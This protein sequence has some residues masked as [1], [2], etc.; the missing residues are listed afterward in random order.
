MLEPAPEETWL[1]LER[2]LPEKWWERKLD[3]P[4]RYLATNLP[5]HGFLEGSSSKV[6]PD[7]VL[8]CLQAWLLKRGETKVFYFLTESC[9]GDQINSWVNIDQL[10]CDALLEVNSFGENIIAAQDYSW[11]L[12][13]DQ[14]GKIHVAGPEELF[15]ALRECWEELGE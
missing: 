3:D 12:F 11:M 13:I 6:P 10:N 1:K 2:L 14:N 15:L 8:Q 7:E 4:K 9:E 5:Y